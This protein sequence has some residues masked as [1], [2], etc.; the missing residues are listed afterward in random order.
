MPQDPTQSNAAPSAEHARRPCAAC[1]KAW[2]ASS[3]AGAWN[4]A[5]SRSGIADTDL[6]AA[7]ERLT[8][9]LAAGYQGEMD[10]MARHGTRRSR[11][12]ELV[13]GTLRVI[14][15]RMDYLPEGQGAVHRA[16]ERPGHRLRLPLCPG[17]RLPQAPAPAPATPGGPHRRGRRPLR[18]PRLRGLG[19]GPGEAPGAEGGPGLDRASHQ[20]GQS[21]GRVLVLPG[22][23][24]Y[25][26]APAGGR[27]GNRPLRDLS[28]LHRRLSDPGHRRPLCPGRPALHLL[29]DHRAGR[30][31]SPRPCGP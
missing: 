21:P 9:W 26:P 13:P 23:A 4:W 24:L 25:G 6:S 28:R 22:G 8:A 30:G 15:V 31:P 17:A 5:S 11:P 14:S 1:P 20:P 16:L 18:L 12:A 27:P 7:E 3:R 29:P 2:R 10:Y 19:P